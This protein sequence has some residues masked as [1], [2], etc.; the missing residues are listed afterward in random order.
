MEPGPKLQELDA[1]RSETKRLQAELDAARSGGGPSANEAHGT[2]GQLGAVD[3]FYRHE[4]RGSTWIY[5]DLPINLFFQK[6]VF[7]EFKL[8][9][10]EHSYSMIV[11]CSCGCT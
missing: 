2:F 11:F 9:E 10:W 3:G 4:T 6:I 8:Q 5:L 1:A 7:A